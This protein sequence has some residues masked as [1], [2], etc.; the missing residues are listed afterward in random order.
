MV[1]SHWVDEEFKGKGGIAAA[2]KFLGLSDK[3]VYSWY[4]KARFPD[5]TN[6][7]LIKIK[8][9]GAVNFE[10]WRSVYLSY[11]CSTANNKKKVG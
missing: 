1:F 11:K 7:E 5:L 2:A 10:F 6:Q 8:S 9:D 4:S 3:T